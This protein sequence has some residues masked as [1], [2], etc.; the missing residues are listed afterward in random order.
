MAKAPTVE[1]HVTKTEGARRAEKGVRGGRKRGKEREKGETTV[2]RR[3]FV[4]P[5]SCT[6]V[7]EASKVVCNPN[8]VL[9]DLPDA[10]EVVCILHTA[11]FGLP[12]ANERCVGCTPLCSS[13]FIPFIVWGG[14]FPA[15]AKTRWREIHMPPH[16]SWIIPSNDRGILYQQ[17]RGSMISCHPNFIS[18]NPPN[19]GEFSFFAVQRMGVA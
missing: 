16:L 3:A 17:Q 2:G 4:P 1:R 7:P 13:F 18:F 9:F 11:L 10:N 14:F 15:T 5:P 12:D 6:I 8:T 19:N